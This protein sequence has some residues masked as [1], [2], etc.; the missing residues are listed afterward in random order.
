MTQSPR[1][2]AF[3]GVLCV[4]WFGLLLPVVGC[5]IVEDEKSSEPEGSDSSDSDSSWGGA[6]ADSGGLEEEGE[7]EGQRIS[8]SVSWGDERFE[9]DVDD[10]SSWKLGMA[11]TGGSCG[12]SV[13]CWT[14][15]D[16]YV[17]YTASDGE[18]YGPWCH[19]VESGS[20]SLDYGGQMSDLEEGTTVFLPAF[21]GTV[22]YLLLPE[23]AERSGGD[24]YVFG[25]RPTY[26]ADLD[27]VVLS[28]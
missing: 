3:G 18:S 13:P 23:G 7:G 20:L 26:Y 5:V 4:G 21:S 28:R 9:L 1:L 14:G 22:T 15:E 11:E 19:D 8:V 17:G 25:D 12:G 27:C 2:S 6:E 24:C 10:G 16:C